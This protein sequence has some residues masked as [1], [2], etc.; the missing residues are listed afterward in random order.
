MPS[1][2]GIAVRKNGDFIL[3][4][5][6]FRVAGLA[7]GFV[8]FFPLGDR[9]RFVVAHLVVHAGAIFEDNVLS[10][11]ALVV[12]NALVDPFDVV[13]GRRGGGRRSEY[14]A[15]ANQQRRDPLHDHVSKDVL[16]R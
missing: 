1:W 10:G 11:I 9:P 2:P 4:P 15:E 6:R 3:L 14:A 16:A 13:S 8:G 7:F 12:G 5:A